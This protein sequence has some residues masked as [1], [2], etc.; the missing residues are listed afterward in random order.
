MSHKFASIEQALCDLAQGKMVILMDDKTRENEGDL[1]LASEHVTP[2]SINFMLKHTSGIICLSMPETDFKRL[3]IPMM[4]EHNNSRYQTPFGV[5]IEAKE[6]VTTGVSAFDRA[7][8]I[9]TAINEHHDHTHIV[10]PGHV[11][12][13]CAKPG[14]VLERNGHTEGCVDLARLAGLKPAAVI[15]EIMNEDGTMARFDDLVIFAKTYGLSI[16]SI[17]ELQE[18]RLQHEE[19]INL[20]AEA[21]LPTERHGTFTIQIFTSILDQKEYVVLRKSL[22]DNNEP[23]LVR[24]HSACLTGDVFGSARCDCGEQLEHSMA[25]IAQSGGVI[26][27]L[28]QEGRGIGLSNKIKAYALQEQGFDT[29]EANYKLGFADDLRDYGLAAQILQR[30]NITTIQ[31]LTNNPR[32][33]ADLQ[34]CGIHVHKRIPLEMKSH[35]T[36]IC[37]LQT[38]RDKLG[39]LINF[40]EF[41]K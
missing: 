11:F 13:L 33:V 17:R 35:E 9:Q 36:N 28:P 39:H 14:G 21:I 2:E 32:K 26:I 41:P 16:V 1:V 19:L 8:T 15:C 10:M 27:Y 6:G 25:L 3:K 30:L 40:K 23:T 20:S 29:V 31:L 5:S 7:H 4:V 37:Y 18:Y 34:R 22:L 12:P 38:K 24:L